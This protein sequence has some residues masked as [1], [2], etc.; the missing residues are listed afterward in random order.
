MKIK[1]SVLKHRE[2]GGSPVCTICDQSKSSCLGIGVGSTPLR[3]AVCEGCLIILLN[4]IKKGKTSL[5]SSEAF[6]YLVGK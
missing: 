5:I 2:G 3:F 1:T 4:T 6:P